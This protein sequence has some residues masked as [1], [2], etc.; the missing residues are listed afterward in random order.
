[1]TE[2]TSLAPVNGA[3]HV[4]SEYSIASVNA[5]KLTPQERAQLILVINTVRAGG[6]DVCV[7]AEYDSLEIG[8]PRISPA[9][10]LELPSDPHGKQ[11]LGWITAAPTS[12][13]GHIYLRMKDLMRG[14]GESAWAWTSLRTEGLRKFQLRGLRPQDA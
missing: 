4:E 14:N 7:F 10:Y 11:H 13:E 5:P 2:N 8:E 6:V 12:K 9:D 3:L 1:M